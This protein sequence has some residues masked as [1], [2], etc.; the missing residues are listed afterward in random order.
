MKAIKK[1]KEK[2]FQD[3]KNKYPSVPDHAISKKKYTDKNTNGLT[4][5]IIDWIQLNGYQA[6]RINST[7]RRIDNRKTVRDVIGRERTIG[8]V[9]WIKG[10]TQTGTA[11]VSATINGKSVKIEV[12]CSATGDKYLSKD[13]KAYRDKIIEAGGVYVIAR[14]FQ[15]F[16]DWYSEFIK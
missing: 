16:Y 15:S 2:A 13:Q 8:S 3:L 11:D 12:K 9:K 10:N 7:G 6:E 5:A 1:L 14:D 4:K